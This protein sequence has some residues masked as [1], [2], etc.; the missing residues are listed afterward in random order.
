M[1]PWHSKILLAKVK[2][3]TF[4]AGGPVITKYLYYLFKN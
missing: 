1:T 3:Q 2:E 4:K